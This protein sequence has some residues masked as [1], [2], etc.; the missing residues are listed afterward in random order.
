MLDRWPGGPTPA[1]LGWL[2]GLLAEGRGEPRS[3]REHFAE[4]LSDPELAQVPFLHA[5]VLYDAG[6][7]ERTLGNRRE[8]IDVLRPGTVDLRPASCH[9]AAAAL[10]GRAQG[11]RAAD[12]HRCPLSLTSREEDIASLVARGYTNKEVGAELFL[13]AKAVDYHLGHIFAKLGVNSRRE[14]RGLHT[15]S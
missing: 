8:A 6:R 13:T 15:V 1:R 7:L 11:V 9:A 5:Q 2:R 4:E 12:D 10:R 3:A 14:L